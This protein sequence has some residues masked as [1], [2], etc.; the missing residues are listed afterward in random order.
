MMREIPSTSEGIIKDHER[1]TFEWSIG[2]M[3]VSH[4]GVP[5]RAVSLG[6]YF[7]VKR[8]HGSADLRPFFTCLPESK[9]LPFAVLCNF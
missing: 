6:K 2:T 8:V 5:S 9:P 3:R 7:R 4:P 1:T